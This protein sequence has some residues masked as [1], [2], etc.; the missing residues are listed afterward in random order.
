MFYGD[1]KV[2][3]HSLPGQGRLPSLQTGAFKKN[4][5]QNQLAGNDLMVLIAKLAISY[6]EH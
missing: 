3:I 2:N 5:F 4:N 6:K 1:L